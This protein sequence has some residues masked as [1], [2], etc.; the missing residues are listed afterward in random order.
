MKMK[1]CV[2]FI[3]IRVVISN[4]ETISKISIICDEFNV[5][6]DTDVN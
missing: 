1:Y 2:E 4:L 5:V 3:N 6:A